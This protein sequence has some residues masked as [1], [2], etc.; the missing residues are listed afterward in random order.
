MLRS[1][2]VLAA[3]ARCFDFAVVIR[4]FVVE[5]FDGYD[6]ARGSPGLVQRSP[7]QKLDLGVDAPKIVVGPALHR[8]QH[9]GVDAQ[10]E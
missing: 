5:W 4:F 8:L 2:S 1:S 3:P 10:Q 9:L 6:F 7:Q